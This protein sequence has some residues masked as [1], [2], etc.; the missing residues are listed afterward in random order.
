MAVTDLTNTPIDIISSTAVSRG[1]ESRLLMLDFSA[2]N[3]DSAGAIHTIFELPAGAALCVGSWWI[4]TTIVGPASFRF[5]NGSDLSDAITQKSAG[6]GGAYNID[7]S[8]DGIAGLY[9]SGT[10]DLKLIVVGGSKLSAGKLVFE[11]N[12]RDIGNAVTAGYREGDGT[13]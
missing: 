7:A 2:Q 3:L 13:V 8:A 12:W 4:H 6:R 5:S 10:T 9:G 1:V 11:V